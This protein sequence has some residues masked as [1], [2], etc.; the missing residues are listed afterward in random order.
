MVQVP[1]A[2]LCSLASYTLMPKCKHEKLSEDKYSLVK[3]FDVLGLILFI[4]AIGTFLRATSPQIP[5]Y[6]SYRESSFSIISLV[7]CLLGL[8]FLAIEFFLAKCPFLPLN[9]L[10][11]TINVFLVSQIILFFAHETVRSKYPSFDSE[12]TVTS[13]YYK[14]SSLFL[15]CRR[16]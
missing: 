12:V 3:N 1:L 4:F 13:A 9:Q 8:L 7:S 10:G 5:D 15:I 11:G 16:I 6:D 2:L 14:P